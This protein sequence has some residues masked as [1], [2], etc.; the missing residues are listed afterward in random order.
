LTQIFVSENSR[1]SSLH[2]VYPKVRQ[3]LIHKT[4][5]ESRNSETKSVQSKLK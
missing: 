3:I 4:L 1:K 2:S 5:I